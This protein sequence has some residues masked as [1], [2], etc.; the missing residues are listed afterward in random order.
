MHD[1]LGRPV[2]VGD[3]L[4]TQHTPYSASVVGRVD[5]VS[6]SNTTCNAML[7]ILRF[8]TVVRE[9]VTLKEC[10]LILKSNGDEPPL[11]EAA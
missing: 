9:T 10:E 6:A 5:T 8:G 11:P 7:S 2:E 4:K 1:R 3:Y